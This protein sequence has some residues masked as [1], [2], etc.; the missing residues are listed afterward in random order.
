[1]RKKEALISQALN[2]FPW[3]KGGS[4]SLALIDSN[5]SGYAVAKLARMQAVKVHQ[6][7]ALLVRASLAITAHSQMIQTL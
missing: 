3:L 1:L 7:L 6:I 2:E 4:R 5:T